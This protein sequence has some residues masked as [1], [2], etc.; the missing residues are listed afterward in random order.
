MRTESVPIRYALLIGLSVALSGCGDPPVLGWHEP[1]IMA[2]GIC[3]FPAVTIADAGNGTATVSYQQADVGG[4]SMTANE[5]NSA[6]GTTATH[7]ATGTPGAPPANTG[8]FT[9]ATGTK[10]MFI[11]VAGC[12]K[13]K[14]IKWPT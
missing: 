6:G 12:A 11:S 8:A 14:T 4:A 3:I 13:T 5:Q 9:P 10:Q 1:K 2:E 7:S